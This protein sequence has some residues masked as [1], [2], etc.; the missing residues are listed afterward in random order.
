MS[1]EMD[2]MRRR[3]EMVERVEI[4]SLTNAMHAICGVAGGMNY[5][6]AEFEDRY[7][8]TCMHRKDDEH[9]DEEQPFS[10]TVVKQ[11]TDHGRVLAW[12]YAPNMAEAIRTAMGHLLERVGRC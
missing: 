6:S 2:R 10:W 8:I 9:Y 3:R 4:R 7:E 5:W 1:D 11:N 12:G